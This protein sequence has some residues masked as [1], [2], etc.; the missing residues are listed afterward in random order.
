MST[1]NSGVTRTQPILP[2]DLQRKLP[3]NQS[4]RHNEYEVHK[5]LLDR[6]DAAE[7]L[8]RASSK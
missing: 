8:K 4:R 7:L 6:P 3:G 2:T 5:S 1:V